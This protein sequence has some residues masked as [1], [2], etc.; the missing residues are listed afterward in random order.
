[1]VLNLALKLINASRL[2]SVLEVRFKHP[3]LLS[4]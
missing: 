1:M 3:S 2:F 4:F